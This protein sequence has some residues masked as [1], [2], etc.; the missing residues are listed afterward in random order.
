MRLG[1]V[2]DVHC[3]IEA[4]Q[5][6][7]DRMGPIDEL[8]CAGDAIYEFR[9]SNDVIRLLRDSGAHVVRGNHEDVLLSQS[10][11]R[12]REAP[13]V[14]PDLVR[15]TAEQPH[16]IRTIVGGKT[17][18][19]FHA[20]P[21]EPYNREYLYKAN[22]NLQRLAEY[23]ADYI[24]YGH[25]HYMLERRIGRALV[26][27]PGSTGQPRDPDVQ[28]QCSAAVLDTETDQVEFVIFPDPTRHPPGAK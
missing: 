4:L 7:L 16:V 24:L 13:H 5:M 26:I 6:A 12:A 2:S 22:P 19:M 18:L 28:F 9:F 10:G 1:I 20:T 8:L 17:L 15:W 11:E 14:E 3:N 23:D 25:T 21:W 27:N